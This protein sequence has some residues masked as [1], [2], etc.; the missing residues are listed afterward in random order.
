MT[1]DER[2]ALAIRLQRA[3]DN[4]AGRYGITC[5][6]L[7]RTKPGREWAEADR[8]ASRQYRALMRLTAALSNLAI[9]VT[10]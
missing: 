8:K 9:G 4:M 2:I 1:T 5:M 7:C 10:R 3:I 6:E